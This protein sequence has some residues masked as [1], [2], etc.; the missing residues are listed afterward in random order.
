MM[1][2]GSDY[3]DGHVAPSSDPRRV[4]SRSRLNPKGTGRSQHRARSPISNDLASEEELPPRSLTP[5]GD[6]MSDPDEERRKFVKRL[7]PLHGV[8]ANEG[9]AG[10]AQI[11]FL[12]LGIHQEHICRNCAKALTV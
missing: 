6:F 12:F 9:E 7:Q 3:P 4:I 2:L 8:G 10:L 1:D 11:S 5:P